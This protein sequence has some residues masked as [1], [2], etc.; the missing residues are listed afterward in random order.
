[1]AITF[2]EMSA[3]TILEKL[4][5]YPDVCEKLKSLGYSV[6]LGTGGLIIT[7][8]GGFIVGSA[9]ISPTKL[10]LLK[11]GTLQEG[12][13]TLIANQIIAALKKHAP[14]EFGQWVVTPEL[15]PASK[16]KSILDIVP[17]INKDPEPPA[18]PAPKAQAW[19]EFP[20]AQ[21]KTAS[22]VKLRDATM[23][24]QPV[25]GTSNSSRYYVIGANK[26]L[27]IAARLQGDALSVR[28]EGPG[29]GKYKGA[30]TLAGFQ[31][32]EDSNQYASLHLNVG[33]NAVLAAKT[34]GAI[35][36][37]LGVK[38]ETPLPELSKLTKG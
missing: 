13:K 11:Q 20:E 12:S 24:Y 15:E 9:A 8:T 26:D 31:K 33:Q 23:M 29:W 34:L 35:L 21:M 2:K 6:T 14:K 1:M 37:G 7:A 16:P 22:L 19:A 30:L 18:E 36:M 27:R 3:W 5:F 17:P 10:S 38:L 25:R 28:V 32:V 4:G